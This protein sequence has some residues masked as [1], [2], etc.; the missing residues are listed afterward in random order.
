MNQESKSRSWSC[1]NLGLKFGSEVYQKFQAHPILLL[2]GV[3]GRLGWGL[4]DPPR[5]RTP[6]TKAPPL[7]RAGREGG[8]GTR[9]GRGVL[10]ALN[11]EKTSHVGELQD[12]ALEREKQELEPLRSPRPLPRVPPD[13]SSG[14]RD[15]VVSGPRLCA[16]RRRGEVH[17]LISSFWAPIPVAA[18]PPQH[19]W[20]PLP[21][22]STLSSPPPLGT[23]ASPSR[24]PLPPAGL[25]LS[26]PDK[27]GPTK[28]QSGD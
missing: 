11:S 1:G 24:H 13:P 28:G 7:S 16:G 18:A 17:V 27:A 5:P 20:A 15:P 19:A 10:G 25:T 22:S 14:R 23:M 8:G 4:K 12:P 26:L 3:L 21:S 2:P 6:C 9:R